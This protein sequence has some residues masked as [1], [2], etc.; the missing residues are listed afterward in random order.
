MKNFIA[1]LVILACGSY[2]SAHAKLLHIIHTNDLHS[3]FQ[4]TRTG[5]G[6]YARLKTVID[7]LRSESREHNIPSLYLDGGDFGEGGSYYFSNNGVDALRALD[8]LGVDVTVLGNHDYI[9]GGKELRDQMK[10]ARLKAKLISANVVG[11]RFI[12]LRKIMPDYYDYNLDGLKVRIFGLTT[13]EI[14]YQ[15]PFR[16]MG[17]IGSSKK[18]GIKMSEKAVED[19]IDFTVALTH[20]GLHKDIELVKNTR[21]IDLVVGGHS[22]TFVPHPEM[23][24]NLDGREIP[25]LQVG[26]H[27]MYV[28]SLLIDVQP[29]GKS[30]IISYKTYD[31]TKEVPEE[32]TM[33]DFVAAAEVNREKYFNRKWD[34]VIGLTEIPLTGYVSGYQTSNRSCWSRHIARL[35][36]K[37]ANADIGF[38]F[39]DLQGE[40]IN[41]GPITFG[42][43]I[44]N[45]P[46]FRKWG[47]QGWRIKK[48]RVQG[49]VLK[50][51]LE[52]ISN[53]GMASMITMDGVYSYQGENNIVNFDLVNSPIHTA[54]ID[55]Y[56]INNLKYYSVALPSEVPHALLKMLNILG[57]VVFNNLWTVRGS[58][59]WPLLEEYIKENSPLR[60]LP[61]QN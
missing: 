44:D 54:M 58:D 13:S 3:M 61:D 56:P 31:I 8:I 4:G 9:L 43:M 59:Y 50:K 16:P 40:H 38:Q 1:A 6:G 5:F 55:G 19:G 7:Q 25:I 33:K 34:E 28:G 49:W 11:K 26:A 32:T 24:P 22:H 21:A 18:A 20:I 23:T 10:E 39:D 51:I 30:T 29:E 35:T 46:H 14:H 17:W 15:Y 57:Y 2:H 48:A 12:G 36:R 60:C 27:S 37:A 53:S 45:F 41:P 52:I 42:D 47:D